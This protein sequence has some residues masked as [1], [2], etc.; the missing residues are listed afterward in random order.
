MRPS[1]QRRVL[2]VKPGHW[3]DASQEMTAHHFDFAGNLEAAVVDR[4]NQPIALRRTPFRITTSRPVALPKGQKKF[5]EMR[6]FVPHTTQN[7]RVSSVLRGQYT[8]AEISRSPDL[9]APMPP[10]QYFFLTLS[11]VP[12]A[13][14][15]LKSQHS[16]V[17]PWHHDGFSRPYRYYQILSPRAEKPLPI[18]QSPLTWTSIAYVLWDEFEPTLLSIEQQQAML[19]WLHFGGQ[20]LISG[21]GSLDQLR[22]SFL[23]PYLPAGTGEV[24]QLND[25]QLA[26]LNQAWTVPSGQRPPAPLQVTRPWSAVELVPVEGARPVAETGG[27]LV[28]RRTG[29]GRVLASA[30]RLNQRDLIAWPSFDHFLNA[31]LLRRPGRRYAQDDLDQTQLSWANPALAPA[32][33]GPIT[34]LRLFSRD[35]ASNTT[36]L[37]RTRDVFNKFGE[38]VD[39]KEELVDLD[40]QGGAASWN[41]LNQVATKSSTALR[42]AAGIRVPKSRFVA[43]MVALYLVVL[44]P[45]NWCFFRLLGR[46]EWA[47]VAAPVIAL[48]GSA[49]VVRMAQLDIGF[50]R[51]QTE[52]AII[53]AQPGYD[54]GHLT[55]FTALYT[56]LSTD[57]DLHFASPTALAQPLPIDPKF[58]MQ[59]GQS[60]STVN[61]RQAA[62]VFLQ[63][64]RIASNSTGMVHSE[65]MYELGGTFHYQQ[66]E[67]GHWSVKN[68]SQLSLEQVGLLRPAPED[69]TRWQGAWVGSLPSGSTAKVDWRTVDST[70]PFTPQLAQRHVDESENEQPDLDTLRGLAENAQWFAPGE[71]RLIGRATGLNDQVRIEP[72]A[73]QVRRATLVV[74]HLDYGPLPLPE[75]DQNGRPPTAAAS[76]PEQTTD[77]TAT[78]E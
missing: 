42:Q 55:R 71:T 49:L 74:V 33:A 32:D 7:V 78:A 75:A 19:D 40:Q 5:L 10:Y 73:S 15:Y 67:N 21:P 51:A 53:E 24:V 8:A 65:Q 62:D 47:W 38:L 28:E 43:E 31:C 30:F 58:K 18:P 39:R 36:H 4:Q 45:L 12:D 25:E 50:A 57:Y 69:N 66:T 26:E 61:Y 56:S 14:G 64:L 76:Q 29:R 3:V 68:A 34:G 2:A 13:Y 77:E 44:V 59:I 70:G 72:A 23:A 1:G 60:Y 41:S 54:R 63:G 17:A 48:V 16:V 20:L 22:G 27:L 46:V 52:I 37:T 6:F 11:R 9:F 35:T